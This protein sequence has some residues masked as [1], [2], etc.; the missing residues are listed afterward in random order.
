MSACD[1][2]TIRSLRWAYCHLRLQGMSREEAAA[3]LPA[4]AERVSEAVAGKEDPWEAL[5]EIL[6][7]S[8]TS[9][10]L[11]HPAPAPPLLRGHIRYPARNGR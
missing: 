2:A 4:L 1:E 8:D 5:A 3:R 11:P 10:R 7:S 6:W 9:A